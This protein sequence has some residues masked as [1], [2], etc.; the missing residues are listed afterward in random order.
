MGGAG[1]V[2][3]GVMVHGGTT[4]FSKGMKLVKSPGVVSYTVVA[5]AKSL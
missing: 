3:G 4:V 5:K 2:G 1:L